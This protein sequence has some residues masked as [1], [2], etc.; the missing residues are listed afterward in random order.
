MKSKAMREEE[1]I[2]EK[3]GELSRKDVEGIKVLVGFSNGKIVIACRD[4]PETE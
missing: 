1:S 3:E 2:H 4:R